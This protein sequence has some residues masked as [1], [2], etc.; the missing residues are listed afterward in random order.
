VLIAVAE[1]QLQEQMDCFLME[2][3]RLEALRRQSKE[4]EDFFQVELHTYRIWELYHKFSLFNSVY[5]NETA[6]NDF[7]NSTS[8]ETVEL[9][10]HGITS[11][12]NAAYK[13]LKT[14]PDGEQLV[15]ISPF[16]Q[17]NVGRTDCINDDDSELSDPYEW[18][19]YEDCSSPDQHCENTLGGLLQS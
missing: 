4:E 18:P 9:S 3:Q 15:D 13:G 11:L 5:A 16:S 17:K 7:G 19:K 14:F 6:S 2:L 10:E 12:T 1:V 8:T